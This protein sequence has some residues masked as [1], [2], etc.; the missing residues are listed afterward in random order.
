M[1]ATRLVAPKPLATLVGAPVRVY[2][3]LTNK[4]WSV[5]YREAFVRPD[6]GRTTHRWRV[7]GHDAAVCLRDAA[8]DVSASGRERVIASGQ[9]EVHAYACGT[10]AS[11]GAEATQSD[12]FYHLAGVC[13]QRIGYNPRRS[14]GPHFTRRDASRVVVRAAQ[15]AFLDASGGVWIDRAR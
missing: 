13:K 4:T 6:N 14:S 11:Y 9:K 10:L 3:N 7:A 12:L 2:R 5:Q 8:F 15:H 1:T